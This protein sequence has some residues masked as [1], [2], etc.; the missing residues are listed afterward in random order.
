MTQ[1]PYTGLDPS[2]DTDTMSILTLPPNLGRG[3]DFSPDGN[4]LAVAHNTSPFLTIYK[5]DGDTFTKLP[6]P[7]ELPTGSWANTIAFSFDGTYLAV[8]SNET[9]GVT[10]YKR[11]EDI[12]TVIPTDITLNSADEVG[13][14]PDDNY[15]GVVRSGYFYRFKRSGDTFTQLGS[16]ISNT[17]NFAFSYNNDYLV[18]T[19]ANIFDPLLTF[20]KRSG[21][22]I[23]QLSD[24]VDVPPNT[25]FGISFS[26]DDTYLAVAHRSLPSMLIYKRDGDTFTKLPDPSEL[27]TVDSQEQGGNIAEFSPDDTYLLIGAASAS[28]FL[29]IYKRSEDTFTKLDPFIIKPTGRAE[30]E[31]S[32]SPD[33]NYLAVA[34]TTFPFLTIYKRDGD[35]FNALRSN[36]LEGLSPGRSVSF[37]PDNTY[38]FMGSSTSDGYLNTYKRHEEFLYC[39][40]RPTWTPRSIVHGVAFSKD[41]NYLSLVYHNSRYMSFY[42]RDNYDTYV[43]M[44]AAWTDP[45]GNGRGVDFSPDGNYLAVAHNTSPFLSIYEISMD[46]LTKIDDPLDLPAGT[47]RGV[48]FSADNNYLAVAHSTA[49]CLTIYE[50]DGATFTKLDLLE[51]PTDVSYHSAYG[52]SFSPDNN[53]LAVAHNHL[54]IYEIS[55]GI[56]TK[57]PDPSDLPTNADSVSFSADNNYL[58]VGSDAA[59][60]PLI[61]YRRSG[62]S[63]TKIDDP[64]E[65]PTHIYGVSFSADNNYL[66]V[67]HNDSP[68]LTVYMKT[69]IMTLTGVQEETFIKLDW[70]YL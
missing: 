63:F 25:P 31:V 35:T 68:Y 32:F 28:P 53:Y 42:K 59:S 13:F 29:N 52:V 67:A 45:T 10:M 51:A 46:S 18:L 54:T 55:E 4:Y 60:T 5:R 37:S 50:R 70:I 14:S 36:S 7:S 40:P 8:G 62:D 43:S 34:H 33:G 48:S 23:N 66:A 2:F 11:D 16:T 41:S 69:M 15:F 44:A 3:V 21:D 57:L 12:F 49:P 56:F 20:Y 39:N 6:D 58:A 26:S 19:R 38:L 1:N 9:P 65:V 64:L 47:G 24:P 61:I 22:N 30:R 27:P 17:T